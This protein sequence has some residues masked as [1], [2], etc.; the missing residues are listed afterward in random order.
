MPNPISNSPAPLQRLEQSSIAKPSAAPKSGGEDFLSMVREQL[1][2]VSQMQSEADDN[3]QKLLTGESAN[4]TEVFTAAR[5]AQ[6]AFSLLLEIRNKLL[7]AY[8][9]V[10][11][12]RV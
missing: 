9:D 11:N 1:E 7:D 6:V 12:M 8:N 3:V 10:Q 2:K 4:M 5:K